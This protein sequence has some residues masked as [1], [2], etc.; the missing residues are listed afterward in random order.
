MTSS[1]IRLVWQ[2]IQHK[3]RQ[4]AESGETDSWVAANRQGGPICEGSN[5]LSGLRWHAHPPIRLNLLG[6]VQIDR[7]RVAQFFVSIEK[8]GWLSRSLSRTP[9]SSKT[10][11]R[12]FFSAKTNS[13]VYS[14]LHELVLR[15]S[16][17]R[18]K[19]RKRRGQD[20]IGVIQLERYLSAVENAPNRYGYARGRYAVVVP[21]GERLY[22][23]RLI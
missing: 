14:S 22:R 23:S 5:R 3:D 15:E 9:R 19:H 21:G 18:S 17:P 16:R 10:D 13:V 11:C 20:A 1:C 8:W 7:P 4:R 6:C 2:P 12:K